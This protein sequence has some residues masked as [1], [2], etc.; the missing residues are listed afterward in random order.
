MS[1]TEEQIRKMYEGQLTS[2]KE[3]L[4]QD[5]TQADADLT[6]QKEKLQKTTDENLNRTAVNAQIAAMNNA[7]YTAA[8]GL[9]SGAQAQAR[10]SL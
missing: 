1:T 7:R 5:Y 8:N 3:Q 9:S 4:Q 6:A 10:L 2:Q